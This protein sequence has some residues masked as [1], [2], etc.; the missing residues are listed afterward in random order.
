MLT[1]QELG[2]GQFGEV[3]LAKKAE[4]YYACKVVSKNK[5]R[6]GIK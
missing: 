2:R 1:K 5:L 4:N 3:F 6:E